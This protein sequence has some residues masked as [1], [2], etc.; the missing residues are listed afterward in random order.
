M[1]GYLVEYQLVVRNKADNADLLVVSSVRGDTAPYLQEPPNGDGASF[2]P[3]TGDSMAASY[4]GLIV[5]AVTSGTSRVVT[6]QLEDVNQR[7]QLGY[8]KAYWKRRLN[9]GSWTVLVGGYLVLLRLVDGITW[10]FN[11]QDASRLQGGIELFNAGAATTIASALATWPNRGCLFGGPIMGTFMSLEDFGGW[12]M[13]VHVIEWGLPMGSGGRGAYWLE[14][15][16]VYGP[17]VDE[18]RAWKSTAKLQDEYVDGINGVAGDLTAGVH[19]A[20]IPVVGSPITMTTIG[21]FYRQGVEFPGLVVLVDGTAFRPSRQFNH[22]PTLVGKMGWKYPGVIVWNDGQT[23]LTNNS[24]VRVRCLT[25]LPSDACPIYEDRHPVDHL[26]NGWTVAAL[27]YDATAATT[28]KNT[29][30]TGLRHS[31]RI[32][33]AKQLGQYLSGAAYKPFG[34][35]VRH[36]SSGQ[37]VPFSTN[38]FANTPPTRTITDAMIARDHPKLPFELDVAQGLQRITFRQKVQTLRANAPDGVIESDSEITLLNA[39]ASALPSGTLEIECLGMVRSDP[40]STDPVG[41]DWLRARALQLFDRFGRGMYAGELPLVRGDGTTDADTL[42]LGDE[43]LINVQELPNHN[44]RLGDDSSVSSRAMQVVH[45]TEGLATRSVRLADSGPN[46]Q[47]LSTKPTH[48]IAAS[49]DSPRTV[50]ELTITNAAALNVLGYAVQIQIAATTGAAP[51]TTDYVDAFALPANSVP[52]TA[53]R[54]P[55]VTA[56]RTL[57]ARTRSWKTGSRPSDWT[58]PVSVA[59]SSVNNPSGLAAASVAGDGSQEDITWTPGASTAD[60]DT[61]VYVRANGAAFSTAVRQGGGLLPG[62][63]AFRLQNLTP[64]AQYIASVQHRD[65]RTGD[66]SNAVDV[67]FTA[68]ASTLTLNPPTNPYGFVNST[69]RVITFGNSNS[70][71]LPTRDAIYGIAVVAVEF[72]GR[73]EVYEALETSIGSGVYGTSASAGFVDAVSGDWTVWQGKAPNDRLRRQLKARSVR[74]GCT[75]SGFTSIVT[76]KPWDTPVL[77]PVVSRAMPLDDSGF[78]ARAVDAA[79]LGLINSVGVSEGG[80]IHKL[81]R[82]REEIAVNGPVANPGESAVTFAQTYQ[83]VPMILP[84]GGQFVT[85]SNTLPAG[86]QRLRLQALNP[87]TSGFTSRSQIASVGATTPRTADFASGNNVTTDGGTA[88]A[89]INPAVANDDTYNV[90]YRVSVT[91][92]LHPTNY[93]TATLVVAIDSND[94]SGWVERA[95]ISYAT[96]NLS[97][98]PPFAANTATFDTESKPIVVSGIGVDDDIRIRAK[99]FSV[100]NGGTGSFSLKGADGAGANP[101]TRNGVTYTTATD[102]TE[103][104]IPSAGD[105]VGWAI[106][107]VL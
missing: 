65:P 45:L 75:S 50:A 68:G 49:S 71:S 77:L 1:P 15:V 31:I 12:Q 42:T 72:P 73:V 27:A 48:T 4:T 5:D 54:L 16:W 34:I 86:K 82:H 101:D 3:L 64:G 52:T 69:Q 89:N 99:S 14:P 78:A 47:P 95:T 92:D 100:N 98:P 107:E 22:D 81:F 66:K 67:S 105:S 19:S 74:E 90:Q 9:G 93:C 13:K 11:I 83:N 33:G 18:N 39:D 88:E 103:S 26:T 62:S 104:A 51:A 96:S 36:N 20:L 17:S 8:L 79:G 25:I 35:A 30:G 41:P 37:L 97:G 32:T 21:D 94:G 53:V 23:A 38:I 7:L 70:G 28:L 102:T 85:Y 6:S 40:A 106:T 43:L 61:D 76:V 55:A 87:T 29:L 46:A 59:L 58:T 63:V 80:A 44:K 56:G 57:Y 60:F 84:K 91:V 24:L 2:D 10:E